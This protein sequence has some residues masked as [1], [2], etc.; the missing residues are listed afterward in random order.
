MKGASC[1]KPCSGIPEATRTRVARPAHLGRRELILK[2]ENRLAEWT[3]CPAHPDETALV[4]TLTP[5]QNEAGDASF[6]SLWPS[7]P[8][9]LSMW[10]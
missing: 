8:L 7:S 1:S 2:I 10:L 9:V 3:G 6:F 5:P 4:G